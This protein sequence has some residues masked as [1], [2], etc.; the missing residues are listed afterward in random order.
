MKNLSILKTNGEKGGMQKG[1]VNCDTSEAMEVVNVET[2]YSLKYVT[3]VSF[4]NA[5]YISCLRGKVP[6]EQMNYENK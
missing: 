2:R 6:V 1:K 5:K 4:S 3:Y